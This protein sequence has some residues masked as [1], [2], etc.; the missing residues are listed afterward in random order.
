MIMTPSEVKALWLTTFPKSDATASSI[1]GEHIVKLYLQN[2]A[3]VNNGI[4][5]NDPLQYSLWLNGD[6]SIQFNPAVFYVK[7]KTNWKA[8]DTV[9]T[10]KITIKAPTAAKISAQFAKVKELIVS[11]KDNWYLDLGSKL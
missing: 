3:E 9:Y 8:Y 1:L 4:R 11:N 10:R 5:E 6:G 7:T 2:K